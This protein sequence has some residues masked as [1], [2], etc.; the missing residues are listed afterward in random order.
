MARARRALRQPAQHAICRAQ[1]GWRSGTLPT[2][3]SSPP[4]GSD[5]R[6]CGTALSVRASANFDAVTDGCAC[7]LESRRRQLQYRRSLHANRSKTPWCQIRFDM[8]HYLVAIQ[9]QNV[10]G[11]FHAER[12]DAVAGQDPEAASI[13]EF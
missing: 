4:E 11:E 9:V 13:A 8:K 5:R 1:V 12:V 3:S 2:D 6:S 7:G 10:D